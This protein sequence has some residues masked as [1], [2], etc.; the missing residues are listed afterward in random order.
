MRQFLGIPSRTPRFRYTEWAQGEAGAELYDYLED[1]QEYT[2]LADSPEHAETMTRLKQLL[3]T[4][5]RAAQ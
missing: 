2:N 4:K 3:D 5:R 1:P